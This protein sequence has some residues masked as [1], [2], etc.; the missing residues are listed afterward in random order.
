[1]RARSCY[2]RGVQRH[3]RN[4]SKTRR[5]SPKQEQAS[6]VRF[7][8]AHDE[9]LDISKVKLNP[10]NPNSHSEEQVK[11]LASI[12]R[13]VG[14]RAPVTISKRSG[15]VVRG[16]RRVA[17]AIHLGS[18]V[19]PVEYQEY[20]SDDMELADLLADN[21]VPE[22]AL[23]DGPLLTK[24]LKSLGADIRSRLGFTAEELEHLL[25][26]EWKP[27]ALDHAMDPTNFTLIAYK[28]TPEEAEVIFAAIEHIRKTEDNPNVPDGR[29]LE[30]ICADFLSND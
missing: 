1:M 7:E 2:T 13:M 28:L 19:V 10:R 8:C 23:L 3:K 17:A 16:H 15:M 5:P 25:T 9:L 24:L 26:D 30:L 14:W 6:D 11:A 18:K 12:I 4:A 21:K 22:L 29:G 20:E 27:P